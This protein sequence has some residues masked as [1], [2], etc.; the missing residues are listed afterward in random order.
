[1][2]VRH[3]GDMLGV[4]SKAEWTETIRQ[5]KMNKIIL[6]LAA[7]LFYFPHFCGIKYL[8]N[9]CLTVNMALTF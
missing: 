3:V 8:F 6:V 4:R 2:S 5:S 1:V 9:Y 7:L